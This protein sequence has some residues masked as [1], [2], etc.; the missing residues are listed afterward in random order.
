M[1]LSL[2]LS[3]RLPLSLCV[4]LLLSVSLSISLSVSLGL[5]L[6]VA[7]RVVGGAACRPRAR[8]DHGFAWRHPDQSRSSCL[9]SAGACVCVS[10]GLRVMP[11]LVLVA[12]DNDCSEKPTND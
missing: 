11:V 4:S 3:L 9:R 6:S 8:V 12:L 10:G 1:S 5:S 7:W 2:P